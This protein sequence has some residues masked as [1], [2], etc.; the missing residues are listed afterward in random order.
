[1][2]LES[3]IIGR[4]PQ[5]PTAADGQLDG[6]LSNRSSCQVQENCLEPLVVDLL[7]I[8]MADSKF[9]NMPSAATNFVGEVRTRSRVYYTSL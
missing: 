8:F 6:Q 5:F 7:S 4:N 3:I 9:K 1:M 2:T